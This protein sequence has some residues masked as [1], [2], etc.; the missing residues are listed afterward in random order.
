M[1]EVRQL[2]ELVPSE[3]LAEDEETTMPAG[4]AGVLVWGAMLPRADAI[5][6]HLTSVPCH[7]C[8]PIVATPRPCVPVTGQ[9]AVL[10]SPALPSTWERE[11]VVARGHQGP[12][13]S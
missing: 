11:S 10:A 9:T 4:G 2:S 5:P 1:E 13:K 6:R 12:G 3:G 7:S 8:P